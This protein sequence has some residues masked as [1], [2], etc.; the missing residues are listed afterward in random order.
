MMINDILNQLA[1]CSEENNYSVYRIAVLDGVTEETRQLDLRQMNAC[2][3]SYSV[4]KAYTMTAIGMLVDDGV[5]DLE[6][7]VTD[8]LVG[9]YDTV[10]DERW[11]QVT[12]DMALTHKIGLPKNFLD[13]DA[14]DPLAFGVDYLAYTFGQR[15][16]CDPGVEYV[17]TDAAYYLL[18]RVVEKRAG[19]SLDNFLWKRLFAP[20]AFREV[21][22][23]HCPK[24]HVLGATGLYIRTDDMVKLGAVY[25]NGGKWR[26]RKIVSEQWVKTALERGYEL[27]PTGFGESYGK[28]G[29]LG[30]MLLVVPNKRLVVGWHGCGVKAEELTKMASL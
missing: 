3:N 2:M 1:A 24:G 16:E 27:K 14:K 23:S 8:I 30:Q 6:E 15:L 19:E 17:Y 13:I 21:A 29:M 4:A 12:V 11:H 7:R 28:G 26:G 25:L 10:G 9:E 5:L 20:L 22:W 18:A